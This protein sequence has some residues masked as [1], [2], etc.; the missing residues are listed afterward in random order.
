MRTILFFFAVLVFGL[1][2]CNNASSDRGI[3]INGVRWAT[4]NVETPGRFASNPGSAGGHFTWEEAK[5][6]C[7]RG[8]RLPTNVELQ[9]LRNAAGGE[10]TAVY[11]ANGRTFGTAPH[12]IFLPAAGLY[13]RNNEI[14]GIGSRGMYWGG[15]QHERYEGYAISMWLDSGGR[16]W[17][18]SCRQSR[19]SVRCVAV[20]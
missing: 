15:T 6:A 8:W 9:S 19:Y 17:D 13:N 20:N 18:W 10:W 5:N 11:G 16:S 12:Q 7:P 4:R 2:S 3:E 1:V 14:T